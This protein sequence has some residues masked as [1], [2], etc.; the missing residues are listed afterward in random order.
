MT[1]SG[2]SIA[3]IGGT[4]GLGLSAA[5]ALVAAGAKL[6]ICGRSEA[7]LDAALSTLGEENACGLHAD[8]THSGTAPELIELLVERFGRLDG[9]FHSGVAERLR[10]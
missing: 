6:G 4:T 3:V 10:R 5:K 7:S 2:K 9:R 1:L 8:A